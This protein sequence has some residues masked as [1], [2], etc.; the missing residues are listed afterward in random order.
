[1]TM[2]AQ[3]FSKYPNPHI[4]KPSE[5][6]E[7]VLHTLVRLGEDEEVIANGQRQFMKARNY[8]ID[9][10]I[11]FWKPES[12]FDAIPY[13]LLADSPDDPDSTVNLAVKLC[14]FRQNNTRTNSWSGKTC[15][16]QGKL[17]P[18]HL[19]V[20]RPESGDG[21]NDNMVAEAFP[22]LQAQQEHIQQ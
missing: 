15:L 11:Q 17:Y 1:M 10:Y 8:S 6:S 3:S 18:Y 2:A 4:K 16:V 14:L 13:S 12:F 19:K 21:A 22:I 5:G 9:C 20:I 7:L